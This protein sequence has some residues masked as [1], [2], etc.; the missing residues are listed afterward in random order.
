MTYQVKF[1][2]SPDPKNQDGIVLGFDNAEGLSPGPSGLTVNFKNKFDLDSAFL[3]AGIYLRDNSHLDPTENALPHP[4]RN[5]EVTDD[6]L[7]KI[8]FDI[9]SGVS[10]D[11]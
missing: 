8:G 11:I 9:T 7:R 5:Y 3:A 1:K 4:D 6:M 10:K 2:S